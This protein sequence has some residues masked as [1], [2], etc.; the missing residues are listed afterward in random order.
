MHFWLD[1]IGRSSAIYAFRILSSDQTIVYAE[2]RRVSVNIDP[3]TL[4]S[5]PISAETRKAAMAL[6]GPQAEA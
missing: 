4:T 1:K 2:G 5:A 3:E 6:L